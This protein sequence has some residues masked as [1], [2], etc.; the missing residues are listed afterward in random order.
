[1]ERA[2]TAVGVTV[3]TATTDDGQNNRGPKYEEI[4]SGGGKIIRFYAR[5]RANLYKFAPGIVP[6]LWSNIRSFDA[7]HIHALFS[8]S[9]VAA[10][11]IAC[12]RGV[13]FIVR[14]LGTLTNYGLTQR[15]LLKPVSLALIEAPLLRRAAAVH[16][17]SDKELE[18]ARE[19]EI[20]MHGVV[21]PLG[22]EDAEQGNPCRLE[23]EY[24]LLEEQKVIL[25]LS[26][27]DSK[28]NVEMLLDA[29]AAIFRKNASVVLV[30]A[31]SGK[32]AYVDSL[33]SRASSLGVRDRV[34]WLGH[35]MGQRKDE[36]FARADVFVLP[37]ASENFGIAAVEAML[38]GIA[39]VL[40]EGVAIANG[41]A[42]DGAA[43]VVAA[44]QNDIA[45]GIM[46][47]LADD[48]LRRE[49]GMQARDH[50]LRNYSTEAMATAL[51]QLY[52]NVAIS[53]YGVGD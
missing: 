33:K 23:S 13:P 12:L 50:A 15:A 32:Q 45:D 6:W 28:K 46:R 4:A 9:S 51:K 3:V 19:L 42:D 44:R 14:P 25:F 41:A 24:P 17:T 36:A 21:I 31:G 29:F 40:G 8:F 27:L 7:V 18:E 1:M 48:A 5:K 11:V 43:F 30:I 39:C 52:S 2:L 53:T 47:L 26:R 49:M 35:V 16:F 37:S 10:G 22:V 20:E 34:L 38:A